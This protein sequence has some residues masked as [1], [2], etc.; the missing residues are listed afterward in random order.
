[1]KKEFWKSKTLWINAGAIVIVVAEYL[2]TEQIIYPE[3]HAV[4]LAV[5]NLGL[6]I[7]TNTGLT[8]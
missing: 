3:L 4:I 2:L 5:V 7:V 6:R 8:K 1:M